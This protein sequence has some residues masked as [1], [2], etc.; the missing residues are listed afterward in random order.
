M[1]KKVLRKKIV[2]KILKQ[3]CSAKLLKHYPLKLFSVIVVYNNFV[4]KIY[5]NAF[6][7]HVKTT[8]CT[9]VFNFIILFSEQKIFR[10]KF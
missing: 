6:T 3:K 2:L 10:Y 9:K 4:Q 7:K 5:T 1:F 8:L